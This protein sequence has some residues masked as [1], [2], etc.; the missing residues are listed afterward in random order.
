MAFAAGSVAAAAQVSPARIPDAAELLR[1]VRLHQQ[2]LDEIRENYTFHESERT[3]ELD[4]Q[5]NTKKT[6]SSEREVFYVNGHQIRRFLKRN[7]VELNAGERAREDE[8]IRKLVEQ[9]LKEP[10]PGGGNGRGGLIS[11]ILA[12]CRLS[13]P[14]RIVLNGRDTWTFEF[15]GDPAA[16]SRGMVEDAAKKLSGTLWIDERDRQVA[17]ISIRFDST[18]RVG[19]FLAAVQ[20]G[21]N[22]TFE[23]A[24]VGDG[25]WLPVSS[26]QHLDVRVAVMSQRGDI[27]LRNSGFRR[28]DVNAVQQIAPPGH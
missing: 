23:Q 4:R 27:H 8:R 9:G 12:V 15:A 26:D 25:L 28:F 11:P 1:D 24:P 20:K 14:R 13:N 21:T 6:I 19:G 18:F 17:K 2:Q 10:R 3:D 22:M 16:K 7:G 5:G